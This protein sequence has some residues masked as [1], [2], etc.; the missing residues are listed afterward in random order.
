VPIEPAVRECGDAGE[1]V[2][3]AFPESESAKSFT[4][5]AAELG[6]L[7]EVVNVERAEREQKRRILPIVQ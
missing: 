7:V 6:K 5:I 4:A 3:S 1:P 2:V